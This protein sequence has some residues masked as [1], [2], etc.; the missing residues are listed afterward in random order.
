MRNNSSDLLQV[1][2][3][4]SKTILR[5]CQRSRN[6]EWLLGYL[7]I[8]PLIVYFILFLLYPTIA[9]FIYGFTSWN[10]RTPPVWVGLEN[11]KK[12]FFDRVAYPYFWHSFTVTLKYVVLAVPTTMSVALVIAL[13]INSIRRM[14]TFFKVCL[15][16]PVITSAVAVAAIWRWVY[17]PL[18]GLLNMVLKALHIQKVNWLGEPAF[19]IPS[20]V[21]IATWS[22]GSS[23]LIYL[24]GLKGIPKQYYEA[25]LIDGVNGWQ[26]FRYITWPLLQPTTFF[27]LITGFIGSFQVFEII[28]VLYGAG[29]GS[30]GG[31]RQSALTYVLYIYNH[32]FRYYEMGT[33]CAMSFILFIIIVIITIIQFKYVRQTY[34]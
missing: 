19:V 27:L 2:Y 3:P 15:Y 31:P 17:D 4:Q 26:Q 22:L 20:L 5:W 1:T 12:L 29:G 8:M 21:I 32:A 33:A 28:Y 14:Q 9:A 25:A 13:L 11:Y 24:A 6:R 7:F 16:L 34:E 30:I 18:Y 10:M 23:M